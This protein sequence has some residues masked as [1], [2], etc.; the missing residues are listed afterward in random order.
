MTIQTNVRLLYLVPEFPSQTHAFF[1]REVLALRA[2]G[3]EVVLVSTRKP[4]ADACRHEFAQSAA[5]QT[6]YLFPPDWLSDT[7]FLLMRPAGL[8]R[9]M[10]YLAGLKESSWPQRLLASALTLPAARL[11]RLSRKFGAS[12]LHVHSFANAAHVAA[13]AKVMGGCSYSLTLHGDLEVYGRDHDSKTRHA[14]FV[15]CVTAPLKRQV[16]ESLGLAESKVHLLWMG[17]DTRRFKPAERPL[18]GPQDPLRLLTVAR[19]HV[20]K[21]HRFALRALRELKDLGMSSRY[22]IVG[23]GPA[24]E[25]IEQEVRSLG[26]IDSVELVGTRSETEVLTLLQ[27]S[28]ALLLTSIGMGEAAPVAVMEAMACGLPVVCSVIGGTRDMI[29]HGHDGFLVGQENV[30]EIAGCIRQLVERPELA[31]QMG[32]A[33]RLRA[34]QRFDSDALAR[35]LLNL[36]ASDRPTGG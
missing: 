29:D 4:A 32:K 3:V 35:A 22:T 30:D 21:G 5:S 18:R 11:C 17:V 20:N 2:Q 24:R 9:A 13:L 19:L 34:E 12:H 27:G 25:E 23:D 8:F 14:R 16:M 15:T 36:V 6:H 33:A 7:L 28:D 31:V 1:W 26:L 10:R